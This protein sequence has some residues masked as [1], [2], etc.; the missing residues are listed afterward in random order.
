MN[1]VD[2]SGWLA[3]LSEGQ[4]AK[5]FAVP[6]KDTANLL[7]PTIVIYEVFKRAATL[8]GNERALEIAGS[9]SLATVVDLSRDLALAAALVSNTHKLAM[10]DSVIYA[11][12]REHNAVL[13]TQDEHFAGL[14]GVKL[15][16]AG[17]RK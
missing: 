2:S 4:H 3:F 16:A 10:A 7:V 8:L 11:T 9:M 14:P 1:L 12:A 13:W 6:L 5:A 15:L 17:V